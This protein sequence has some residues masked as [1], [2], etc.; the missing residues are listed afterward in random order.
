MR[1]P[2]SMP[3]PRIWVVIATLML[4]LATVLLWCE[5]TPVA[6]PR[7]VPVQSS[8]VIDV[9]AG[10]QPELGRTS[11]AEGGE[12]IGVALEDTDP[13]RWWFLKI[14]WRESLA[15]VVGAAI[16][17]GQ[18][19]QSY[20]S[21][22][23]GECSIPWTGDGNYHLRIRADGA[24]PLVIAIPSPPSGSTQP[25]SLVRAERGRLRVVDAGTG[26][27]IE[28]AKLFLHRIRPTRRISRYGFQGVGLYAVDLDRVDATTNA[29]GIAVVENKDRGIYSLVVVADGYATHLTDVIEIPL[30]VAADDISLHPGYSLRVAVA[31]AEG[32]LCE[33]W[34]VL[35]TMNEFAHLSESNSKGIATSIGFAS[36]SSV[37]ATVSRKTLG[38]VARLMEGLL[39]PVRL[40]QVVPCAEIPR[41]IVDSDR[42]YPIEVNWPP[43][44][45][46]DLLHI[47]LVTSVEGIGLSKSDEVHVACDKGA[48]RLGGTSLGTYQIVGTGTH[49]GIWRSSMFPLDGAKMQVSLREQ[50]LRSGEISGVVTCNATDPLSD[51]RIRLYAQPADIGLPDVALPGTRT[52]GSLLARTVTTESGEFSFSRLL[53][54]DYTLE[55]VHAN[56]AT[57]VRSL[58]IDPAAPLVRTQIET[59][60]G[61][62]IRGIVT[63]FAPAYPIRVVASLESHLLE[64]SCLVAADGSF[65]ICNLP[66]GRYALWLRN[67]D[68]IHIAQSG[69]SPKPAGKVVVESAAVAVCRL[70]LQDG[71]RSIRVRFQ[72]AVGTHGLEAV[73]E[74]L[75]PFDRAGSSV[76]SVARPLDRTGA[77]SFQRLS[78][79]ASY[80]IIVRP[81]GSTKA[82]A[83]SIVP[84][85]RDSLTINLR[86]DANTLAKVLITH[87]EEVAL[88]PLDSNGTPLRD[89]VFLPDSTKGDVATFDDIPYGRYRAVRGFSGAYLG[90]DR[91]T[92]DL[93]VGSSQVRFIFE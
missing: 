53:P 38:P 87:G 48:A 25:V 58:R 13:T 59:S 89:T 91:D 78:T 40:E 66:P 8:D 84:R 39:A 5:V 85:G 27:P 74:K 73:A 22:E 71:T 49:S 88:I 82:H 57:A 12:R 2:R 28:G 90:K 35:F 7:G 9:S 21:N 31:D 92:Q 20:T 14:T 45:A 1:L 81:R 51:A 83:W 63:D 18:P 50:V 23:E 16:Y 93:V 64:H 42:T 69:L 70:L 11:K 41:L 3:G 30:A 19:E 44:A 55:V 34:K 76:W 37:T 54:G 86:A 56:G 46:E 24:V 47:Q 65:S 79:D 80:G 32:Q 72:G 10:V 67:L 4:V 26:G 6:T 33:D 17:T 52:V 75:H 60:V 15:P 36:G 62:A 29:S 77:T 68:P 43:G 61:G